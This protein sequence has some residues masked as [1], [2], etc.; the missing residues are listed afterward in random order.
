[1]KIVFKERF[2]QLLGKNVSRIEAKKGENLSHLEV[3][4]IQQALKLHLDEKGFFLMM[5]T[6]KPSHSNKKKRTKSSKRVRQP[7]KNKTLGQSNWLS[8]ERIF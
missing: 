3:A 6:E 1:M 7:Q 2:E 4:E 8:S 5:D